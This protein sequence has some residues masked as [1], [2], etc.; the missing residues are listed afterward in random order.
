[1]NKFAK[2]LIKIVYYVLAIAFGV[3]LVLTLPYILL[4][5]QL[6]KEMN[7]NLENGEFVDAMHLIGCYYDSEIAYLYEDAQKDIQL[8]LFRSTPFVD[9]TYTKTDEAG[10]TT[11][12]VSQETLEVGYFPIIVVDVVVIYGEHNVAQF[13]WVRD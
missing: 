5:S 3:I 10:N 1:M 2:T 12:V 7:D 11:E 13:S 8:V 4:N 6:T 9:T